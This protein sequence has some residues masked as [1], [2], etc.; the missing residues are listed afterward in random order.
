M[1]KKLPR[2]ITKKAITTLLQNLPCLKSNKLKAN[3]VN[4]SPK[5]NVYISAG[6]AWAFGKSHRDNP[7]KL[8]SSLLLECVP[9]FV[10]ALP[11]MSASGANG[12]VGIPLP[13][14]QAVCYHTN[15]ISA[16]ALLM[17]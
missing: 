2:P 12:C 5:W 13:I 1:V 17:S 6:C 9:E 7:S 8:F 3:M 10:L 4:L 15:M 14:R 16:K 11:Y